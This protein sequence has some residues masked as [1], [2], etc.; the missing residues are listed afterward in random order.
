[1]DVHKKEMP[2][3]DEHEESGSY[4][5]GRGGVDN[6]PRRLVRELGEEKGGRR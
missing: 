1:M 6:S 4:K 3:R 5:G 2:P